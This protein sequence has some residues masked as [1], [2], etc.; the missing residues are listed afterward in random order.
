MDQSSFCDGIVASMYSWQGAHLEEDSSTVNSITNA[1]V[2]YD[3]LKSRHLNVVLKA[4]VATATILA[5]LE[6]R[7]W[8][9][10]MVV[11]VKTVDGEKDYEASAAVGKYAPLVY[12]SVFTEIKAM[13]DPMG[14]NVIDPDELVTYLK[15]AK[16]ASDVNAGDTKKGRGLG[17]SC[18]ARQKGSIELLHTMMLAGVIQDAM[19]YGDTLFPWIPIWKGIAVQ[20]RLVIR[21]KRGVLKP[22]TGNEFEMELLLI[23]PLK[24]G[25]EDTH[26]FCGGRVLTDKRL[27]YTAE[28]LVPLLENLLAEM[29]NRTYDK[30]NGFVHPRMVGAAEIIPTGVCCVCLDPCI[31]KTKCQHHLCD[32]CWTG[33]QKAEDPDDTRGGVRCPMCRTFCPRTC[34]ERH[35]MIA[36]YGGAEVLN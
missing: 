31:T 3:I 17:I 16:I 21:D 30:L 13:K 33:V 24:A 18:Y 34:W 8:V 23:T 9:P 15:F 28:T 29:E 5:T 36:K 11:T 10:H 4:T 2:L 6:Y 26:H 19:T 20:A 7:V 32:E 25:A 27:P 14:K 12:T 35:G 22:A 1:L